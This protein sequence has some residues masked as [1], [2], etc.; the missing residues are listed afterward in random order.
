MDD[1]TT[2]ILIAVAAVCLFA[3]LVNINKDIN[4]HLGI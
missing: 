2:Y 4:N 1:T 3:A